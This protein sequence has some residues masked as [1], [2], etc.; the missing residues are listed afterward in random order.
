[1]SQMRSNQWLWRGLALVSVVCKK[2]N[3][4]LDEIVHCMLG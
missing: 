1:M 2:C 4:S 3:P